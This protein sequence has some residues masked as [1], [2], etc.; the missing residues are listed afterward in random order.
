M[1]SSGLV[2]GHISSLL[3]RLDPDW[4]GA[5]TAPPAPGTMDWAG[6]VTL[7]SHKRN[8]CINEAIMSSGVRQRR[9]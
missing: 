2:K 7:L 1:F 4:P 6:A 3:R 9:G 8:R 5:E